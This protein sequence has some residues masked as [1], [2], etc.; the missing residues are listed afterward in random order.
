LEPNVPS[1]CSATLMWRRQSPNDLV[2]VTVIS[3][4]C[5]TEYGFFYWE[6]IRKQYSV[7]CFLLECS[8]EIPYSHLE[9]SVPESADFGFHDSHLLIY[10]SYVM[11]PSCHSLNCIRVRQRVLVDWLVGHN[12]QGYCCGE[13]VYVHKRSYSHIQQFITSF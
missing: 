2:D 3:I 12:T 8:L 11:M 9:F 10:Q 6:T 7:S 4:F 13:M 1:L 5:F